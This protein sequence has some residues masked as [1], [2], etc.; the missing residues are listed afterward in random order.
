[1]DKIAAFGKAARTTYKGVVA[2]MRDD[3]PTQS[4]ALSY[5]C[6]LCRAGEQ[7][8]NAEVCLRCFNTR[9]Q[10]L[11]TRVVRTRAPGG[12]T[13]ERRHTYVKR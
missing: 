5:P 6:K 12:R 4:S 7:L 11:V 2:D 13:I 3:T 8:C 9:E 1:M 10:D